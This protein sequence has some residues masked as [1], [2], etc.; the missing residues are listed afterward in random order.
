M[1]GLSMSKIQDVN[2]N[3]EVA[4]A[5]LRV[6]A[7]RL[8]R[9]SSRSLERSSSA[10]EP[11]CWGGSQGRTMR[12]LLSCMGCTERREQRSCMGCTSTSKTG[13]RSALSLSEDSETRKRQMSDVL[14][15]T[16][17][18]GESKLAGDTR[19]KVLLRSKQGVLHIQNY[20]IL[21]HIAA[22]SSGTVKVSVAFQ[23]SFE[24]RPP[25]PR[26]LSP[27]T[28]AHAHHPAPS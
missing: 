22:G 9:P 18:S 14:Q 8:W 3:L 23:L 16:D 26:L 1:D 28:R 17:S 25:S 24:P 21:Q 7:E 5:R 11:T 19:D 10:A 13:A 27:R 6:E 12:I 2:R 4:R 20:I 15:L